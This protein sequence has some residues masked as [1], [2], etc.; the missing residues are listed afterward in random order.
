MH[1]LNVYSAGVCLVAAACFVAVYSVVARWW[2]STEGRLLVGMAVTVALHSVSVVVG[3][4]VD[5]VNVLA[6][7]WSAVL[8]IRLTVLVWWS[9]FATSGGSGK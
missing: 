5:T 6:F 1:V 8:M 3:A 2:R 9:Q 7:M 4:G